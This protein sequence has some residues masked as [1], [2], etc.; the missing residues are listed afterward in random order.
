MPYLI[1][2]LEIVASVHDGFANLPTLWGSEVRKPGKANN[3]GE[4]VEEGVKG[5]FYSYYDGI[6]GLVKD[7]IQGG[8]KEVRATSSTRDLALII[9]CCM[10]GI[11]WGDQRFSSKL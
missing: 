5:F 10:V 2:I 1:G 4:G 9:F 6:T 3:F 7:P 8:K 11:C